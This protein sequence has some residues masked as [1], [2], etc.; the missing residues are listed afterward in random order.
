MANAGVNFEKRYSLEKKDS[1][2]MLMYRKQVVA[3]VASEQAAKYILML[4]DED[5]AE[6]GP[7]G[8]IDLK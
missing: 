1:W 8:W 2:T 6:N 7:I 3:A 4:I 5:E